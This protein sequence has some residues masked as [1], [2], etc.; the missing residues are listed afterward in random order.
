V[1]WPGIPFAHA[2]QSGTDVTVSR[3]S[4]PPSDAT[5]AATPAPVG[6]IV[7]EDSQPKYEAPATPV[8]AVRRFRRPPRRPL[9]KDWL[10]QMFVSKWTTLY[11]LPDSLPN[12]NLP[13]EISTDA[14]ISVTVWYPMECEV[15][16]HYVLENLVP[17]AA[18]GGTV[19]MRQ[20]YPRTRSSFRRHDDFAVIDD[21]DESNIVVFH[22]MIEDAQKCDSA[23]PEK[24]QYYQPAMTF[25][26]S[27]EQGASWCTHQRLADTAPLTLRQYSSEGAHMPVRNNVVTI[28]LGYNNKPGY[29]PRNEP[30]HTAS[31]RQLTWAWM[32]NVRRDRRE[33]LDVLMKAFPAHDQQPDKKVPVDAMMAVYKRAKFVPNAMGQVSWDCFRLYEASSA[34]AIPVVCGPPGKIY[35]AFSHFIGSEG[36]LPPWIYVEKW[37]EAPA[38][39]REFLD[40]ATLLDE[41]QQRIL[42][43][44]DSTVNASIAATRRALEV[45]RMYR[46]TL[47]AA[48]AKWVKAKRP[49]VA[50]LLTIDP[51]PNPATRDNAFRGLEYK[52]KPVNERVRRGTAPPVAEPTRAPQTLAP[53]EPPNVDE[54]H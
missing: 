11:D 48:A 24:A 4:R 50:A 33:M 38:A 42:E 36:S 46:D 34:G 19:T 37:I 54:Y 47:K 45:D 28:P 31:T 5:T 29:V 26:M 27:D 22:G 35:D 3:G 30:L 13:P 53:T 23:V 1:P 14:P 20:I 17:A 40:N 39:M 7:F 15:E 44:W 6:A 49:D 8:P 9:A 32:G 25:L 10:T 51:R 16:K 52:G 12:F 21:P 18:K 41:Q 43:W 2:R